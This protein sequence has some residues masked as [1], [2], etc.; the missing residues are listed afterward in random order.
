[1]VPISK[2]SACTENS[3]SRAENDHSD[4]DKLP[5]RSSEKAEKPNGNQVT[6]QRLASNFCDNLAKTLL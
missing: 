2:S 4:L 1:M 5:L 6:R 3:V